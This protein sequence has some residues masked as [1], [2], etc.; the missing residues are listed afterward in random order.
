MKDIW[1]LHDIMSVS[2]S[3]FNRFPVR[4]TEDFRDIA[5]RF[6]E[7]PPMLLWVDPNHS[8][9]NTRIEQAIVRSGTKLATHS[10]RDGEST[11]LLRCKADK[12]RTSDVWTT[13]RCC[14]QADESVTLLRLNAPGEQD[15][16]FVR[17][18]SGIEG[19]MLAAHLQQ[20]V[21][22]ATK[23]TR[24]ASTAE[25]LEALRGTLRPYVSLPPSRFRV[26]TNST[27]TENGERNF[28]AGSDMAHSMRL[29]VSTLLR[30]SVAL[31]C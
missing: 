9:S 5:S 4:S 18:S 31:T 10:R 30:S 15:F 19:F 28:S 24:V 12:A 13:P 27:R 20:S 3:A 25:A 14:L 16:A 17:T 8:D 29:I 6:Q 23:I 7:L 21:A 26:M 11:T 1:P 2:L 22:R